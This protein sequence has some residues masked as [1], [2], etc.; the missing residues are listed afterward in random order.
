M[1]SFRSAAGTTPR[2]KR[3]IEQ[4]KLRRK[5]GSKTRRQRRIRKTV[6]MRKMKELK[7][8]EGSYPCLLAMMISEQNQR[9]VDIL[10]SAVD[11]FIL[12]M[13][14]ILAEMARS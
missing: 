10:A 9:H 8:R 12:I 14:L 6:K 7:G 3:L 2:R 1:S 11:C 13:R 4:Q 5:R